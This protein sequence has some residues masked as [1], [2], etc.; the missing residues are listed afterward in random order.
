[1]DMNQPLRPV[2]KLLEVRVKRS[3]DVAKLFAYRF[4]VYFLRPYDASMPM[5]KH[6]TAGSV[7]LC[8]SAPSAVMFWFAADVVRHACSPK[9][10]DF[11]WG[12]SVNHTLVEWY[13]SS[14]RELKPAIGCAICVQKETKLQVNEQVPSLLRNRATLVPYEASSQSLL[15]HLNT[16]FGILKS[17]EQV[18]AIQ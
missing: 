3:A 8:L 10:S 5:T 4:C 11:G 14:K 9:Y 2:W 16:L 7:L 6:S 15:W 12:F 1:M 13:R 17:M 18:P